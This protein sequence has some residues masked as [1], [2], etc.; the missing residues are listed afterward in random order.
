MHATKPKAGQVPAAT[1]LLADHNGKLTDMQVSE[2]ASTT[3]LKE[4]S[5]RRPHHQA[6]V[7]TCQKE[8]QDRATLQG[9]I[10]YKR[11]P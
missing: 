7:H 8:L 3:W 6:I 10:Q 11:Q 5:K 4:C 1:P 9:F 2:Q